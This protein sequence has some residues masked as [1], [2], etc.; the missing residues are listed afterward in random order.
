[1]AWIG[2]V[3]MIENLTRIMICN[4]CNN[5]VRLP[6][7]EEIINKINEIIDYINSEELRLLTEALHD[8]SKNIDVQTGIEVQNNDD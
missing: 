5:I 8:T 1:M 4:Y 3:E 7:Q 2:G 6:N